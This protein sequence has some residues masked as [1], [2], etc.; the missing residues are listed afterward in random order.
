MSTKKTPTK[1]TAKKATKAKAE[2][3][4]DQLAVIIKR[5]GSGQTTVLAE[6]QALGFS[7]RKALRNALSAHLGGRPKYAALLKRGRTAKRGE[8]KQ[9]ASS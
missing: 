3:T 4:K 8:T 1:K 7:N 2:I 6:A 5:L 9:R